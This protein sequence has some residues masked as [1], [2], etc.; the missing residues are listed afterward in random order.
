VSPE[1]RRQPTQE[2][3]RDEGPTGA[4]WTGGHSPAWFRFTTVLPG[5]VV[6]VVIGLVGAGLLGSV[7]VAVVVMLALQLGLERWARRD[8]ARAERLGVPPAGTARAPA[9]ERV[10]VYF[11]LRRPPADPGDGPDTR[12]TDVARPRTAA[13]GTD[14]GADPRTDLDAPR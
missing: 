10:L 12:A 9:G 6:G 3:R 5:V 13:P 11:G 2:G 14:Q 7:A 8:P 1:R 4:Y